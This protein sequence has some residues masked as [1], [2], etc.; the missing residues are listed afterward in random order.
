MHQHTH[1]EQIRLC[2]SNYTAQ[3]WHQ[4]TAAGTGNTTNTRY[5]SIQTL[6][7][8]KLVRCFQ[9]I[10]FFIEKL[11][12]SICAQEAPN[13]HI[14]VNVL[15]SDWKIGFQNYLSHTFGL[16]H[17]HYYRHTQRLS[18]SVPS[19]VLFRVFLAVIQRNLCSY[20]TLLKRQIPD[21]TY[22]HPRQL[23]KCLF[24]QVTSECLRQYFRGITRPQKWRHHP[25]CLT[26]ISTCLPCATG[27]RTHGYLASTEAVPNRLHAT[28]VRKSSKE[29]VFKSPW[30]LWPCTNWKTR[31]FNWYWK[32][33]GHGAHKQW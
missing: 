8:I 25:R 15:I 17:L 33:L 32:D 7:T 23:M 11:I 5:L 22:S 3:P 13:S 20:P 6:H 16:H 10:F 29:K 19:T 12:L 2:Q 28:A 24:A 1:R 9:D 31:I 26:L 27:N 4:Y 30:E 18:V 14:T 21:A